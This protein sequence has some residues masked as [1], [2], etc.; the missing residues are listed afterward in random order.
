[1]RYAKPELTILS[2]ATKVIQGKQKHSN[3]IQDSPTFLTASA[4]EADE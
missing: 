1:M 3:V 2:K 4:Y